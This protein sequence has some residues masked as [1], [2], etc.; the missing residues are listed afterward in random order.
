MPADSTIPPFHEL[1]A[2]N[3]CFSY[4]ATPALTNVSFRATPGELIA[5]VGPNGCGKS[6]LLKLLIGA[7]APLSGRLTLDSTP[8]P[9]LSR[10]ALARRLALVPQMAGETASES[11]WGSGAGFTVQQTVLMARYAAHVDE[12]RSTGILQAAGGLGIFGFETPADEDIA[13]HAMWDSDVHHLLDRDLDTLSGGERQRVAIA[14]AFAQ[15]TPILLLD[16]PTSALDLYHQLELLAQ[17]QAFTQQGRLI[18]L[19]T[20]DLNL[21][22]HAATR[23]LVMDRGRIAADGTPAQTLTPAILEPIY[24]VRVH[25]T[26]TSLHFTRRS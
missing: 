17:L 3:L 2:D 25:A 16:E 14:R 8:L 1:A 23:V 18:L 12:A 19:V 11:A 21:A 24:Q 5:I 26:P 10:I 6:T 15:Q 4:A 20:H 22:L 9:N 13:R 7:L